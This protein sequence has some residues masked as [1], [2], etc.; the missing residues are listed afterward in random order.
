MFKIFTLKSSTYKENMFLLALFGLQ[1]VL[2]GYRTR[3]YIECNNKLGK[4]F[5]VN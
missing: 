1:A 3:I 2:V 4:S 5:F